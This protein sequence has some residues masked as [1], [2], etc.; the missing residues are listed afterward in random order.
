MLVPS[1]G[2]YPQRLTESSL[3]P[4]GLMGSSQPRL[5]DEQLKQP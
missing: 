5:A 3:S 2:S 1:S 4:R